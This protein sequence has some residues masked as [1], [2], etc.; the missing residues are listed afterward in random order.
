MESRTFHW[1]SDLGLDDAAGFIMQ[2]ELSNLN[3][4]S[5]QELISASYDNDLQQSI[6]SSESFTLNPS[7]YSVEKFMEA[8]Q[9][10][11]KADQNG[12]F[13]VPDAPFLLSF[14]QSQVENI[15]IYDADVPKDICIKRKGGVVNGETERKKMRMGL[16]QAAYALDHI[17]AERRRREKLSERFVALAAII[18]GLKKMDKASVLGDAV[19]HI[20][21]LEERVK[22]LEE[23]KI[24]RKAV[25]IATMNIIKPCHDHSND[26]ESPISS[27]ENNNIINSSSSHDQKLHPHHIKVKICD[28]AVLVNIH[29]E[30]HKGVLAK[31]A[32]DIEDLHLMVSNF[33]AV[34]FMGSSFLDITVAAQV[35][36]GSFITV[37][38]VAKKL[39]A[40][41]SQCN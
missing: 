12:I 36:D 16:G 9:G 7:V 25:E 27:V 5:P 2:Q 14:N 13:L 32:S 6:S 24:E 1:V 8:S 41:L 29:C 35:E 15:N 22:N 31:L 38:D 19:K 18:P 3:Q 4:Y 17:L 30:N 34:P 10:M 28:K 20:K 40:A 26:C 23:E 33:S 37:E 39:N 11:Y 21:E